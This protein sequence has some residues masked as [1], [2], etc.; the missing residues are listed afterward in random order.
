MTL[1]TWQLD[2][3][4]PLWFPLALL[5]V[6][7]VGLFGLAASGS[8]GLER[9]T[10]NQAR[11]I[12]A[13]S[14]TPLVAQLVNRAVDLVFAAIA[15]R[16]LGVEGNGEYAIAS[17]TWLY[18]KTITDFGLSILVA[19]EVARTPQRAG[20]LVGTTTLFRWA[21]LLCLLPLVGALVTTGR[22]WLGLSPASLTAIVILVISIVPAS[23]SE[24]INSVFTGYERMHLPAILTIF[25]NLVRFA[26]GLLALG[27]GLGVPGIAAAAVIAAIC[28]AAA[29]HL[30][31]NRQA[32]RI[33]WVCSLDEWRSLA[34][35]AWP[36]LL[37]GLLITVFFRVDTFVIQAFDGTYSLG[38][39]DAAYKLPN[40]VP[41]IP[42]Y[43]VLAVFPLLSRQSGDD[44]RRSFEL[45]AKFLVLTGWLIVL[46]TLIG[47][48]LFIRILGGQAFLPEAAETLRILI[49][50]T[51]LH[52]LNGIAQYAVIAADRQ[53]AIAPAY[54]AATIF[55]LLGNL[56]GVPL[57]GY[58]AA[59]VVTVLTEIVLLLALRRAL[60]ES[61]GPIAW[62]VLLWRPIPAVLSA[63]AIVWF[64]LEYLPL[65]MVL[66]LPS[67]FA[68]LWL[69]GT[70]TS[71]DVALLQP[72][73]P[74]R[75]VER[76]RGYR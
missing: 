32:M 42:S 1:R 68:L 72:L 11:R 30:A 20:R 8:V 52:F 33:E 19:R 38:I 29:F 63:S 62:K 46:V 50:F 22:D 54:I 40:L 25:T 43:F 21:V 3:L 17:V 13:N 53:R 12:L 73:L 16:I 9:L 5:A 49:W 48:P 69:T 35:S 41:L 7:L 71:R 75:L 28:N 64:A 23:Y 70:V 4:L 58:R 65:A 61:L 66:A 34:K 10:A 44:R 15:L 51:P 26:S 36:L 47:A 14:A 2:P 67:Y 18:L 57:F 37:N 60:E 31:I 74:H 45:G 59:A 39:Y 6:G 24:A 56:T 76:F 27:Y 55:N